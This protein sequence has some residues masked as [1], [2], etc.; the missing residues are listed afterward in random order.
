MKAKVVLIGVC[1]LAA[2][3]I[4]FYK[5]AGDSKPED[6]DPPI[7]DTDPN[8]HLYEPPDG[9]EPDT[10]P[11]FECSIEVGMEK[12]QEIAYLTVR[13]IHGWWVDG[14]LVALWHKDMFP[15]LPDGV[16]PPGRC[17]EHLFNLPIQFN[18]THTE[19]IVIVDHNDHPGLELGTSEDWRCLV[20][21]WQ[22]AVAPAESTP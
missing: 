20:R 3:I 2:G 21:S 8:A 19:R 6:G 10:D 22:K 12:K 13:E 5:T 7:Q 16:L 15:N 9:R 11:V 1:L 4:Y 14:V 18:E 17:G